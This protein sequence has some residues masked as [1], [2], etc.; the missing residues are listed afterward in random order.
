MRILHRGV[1]GSVHTGEPQCASTPTE[2]TMLFL[3]K[4]S[5]QLVPCARQQANR[6]CCNRHARNTLLKDMPP[7][8]DMSPQPSQSIVGDTSEYDLTSSR[9]RIVSERCARVQA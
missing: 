9:A 1:L 5:R 8:S 2:S 3:H 7:S 6:T 4:K